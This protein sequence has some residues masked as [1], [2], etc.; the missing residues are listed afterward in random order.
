MKKMKKLFQKFIQT[1]LVT[2]VKKFKIKGTA[3]E[4]IFT[5]M[6]T[7]MMVAGKMINAMALEYLKAMNN[8]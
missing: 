4:N 2:R 8:K 7:F 6:D 1:E 5:R 3:E